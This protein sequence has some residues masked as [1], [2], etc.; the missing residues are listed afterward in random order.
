[1]ALISNL[2]CLFTIVHSGLWKQRKF[3]QLLL[4]NVTSVLCT[5]AYSFYHLS[6]SLEIEQFMCVFRFQMLIFALGLNSFVLVSLSFDCFV[7]VYWPLKFHSI[8]TTKKFWWSNSSF[9]GIFAINPL[10][11]IPYFGLQNDGYLKR[12][13]DIVHI[14]PNSYSMI[15][16]FVGA[17]FWFMIFILNVNVTVGVFIALVKRQNLTSGANKM[18]GTLLK[19]VIRLLAIVLFN[20]G[21][22]F[23]L[24]VTILR[25]ELLY[26]LDAFGIGIMAGFWNVLFFVVSDGDLRIS[27]KETFFCKK[28]KSLSR[29]RA[30]AS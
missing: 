27:F 8:M 13:C 11:S 5:I 29:K 18:S 17:S 25:V 24:T 14:M 28:K 4:L 30:V 19:L 21:S 7:A 22:S 10:V 12:K 9:L 3:L 1:M 6:S 20:V 15:I 2:T 23:P 16:F 26:I